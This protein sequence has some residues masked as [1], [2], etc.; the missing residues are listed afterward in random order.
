MKLLP[1]PAEICFIRLGRDDGADHGAD[2]AQ[3][4][5]VPERVLQAALADNG[6]GHFSAILD[7]G[8]GVARHEIER[9]EGVGAVGNHVERIEDIDLLPQRSAVSGRDHGGFA[10][11]VDDDD[12]AVA[13]QQRRDQKVASFAATGLGDDQRVGLA[14]VGDH[15]QV[16]GLGFPASHEADRGLLRHMLPSKWQ[17]GHGTF[18][19]TAHDQYPFYAWTNAKTFGRMSIVWD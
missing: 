16:G 12:V 18:A 14:L 11:G 15:G 6:C 9:V 1:D 8:I 4:P 13:F 5:V 10:L 19:S 3:S 17:S 7:P 2:E